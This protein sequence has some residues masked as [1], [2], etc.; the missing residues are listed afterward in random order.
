MGYVRIY[1]RRRLW[2]PTRDQPRV[3]KWFKGT[4]DISGSQLKVLR[5]FNELQEAGHRLPPRGPY[6]SG[7]SLKPLR[8]LFLLMESLRTT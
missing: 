8:P 3:R 5:T 1:Y 2:R 6:D 4:G 7:K